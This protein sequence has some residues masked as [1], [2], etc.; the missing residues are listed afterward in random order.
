MGQNITI[1]QK[2]D[3]TKVLETY[4][5][6]SDGERLELTVRLQN[7][8]LNGPLTIQSIYERE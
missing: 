3:D 5:F 7:K 1:D 8:Q 6:S 2:A 4:V